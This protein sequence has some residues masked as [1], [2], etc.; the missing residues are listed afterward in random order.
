M[1]TIVHLHI[2]VKPPFYICTD[3]LRSS[4]SWQE[5]ESARLAKS[6]H[7]PYLLPVAAD[8]DFALTQSSRPQWVKQLYESADAH[9]VAAMEVL[10]SH[11]TGE[12]DEC[13]ELDT[14]GYR[15]SDLLH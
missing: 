14:L 3:L 1:K 10:E 5:R 9:R 12:E 8:S 15:L 13:P 11:G 6:L 4:T 2:D 7:E